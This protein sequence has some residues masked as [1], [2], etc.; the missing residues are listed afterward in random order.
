MGASIGA[1]SDLASRE[2][3]YVMAQQGANG[4]PD[5]VLVSPTDYKLDVLDLWGFK[6]VRVDFPTVMRRQF[7]IS[8]QKKLYPGN[9]PWVK[10]Q[11]CRTKTVEV[12]KALLHALLKFSDSSA[13]STFGWLKQSVSARVLDLCDTLR[14]EELPQ[15]G[16]RVMD[17]APGQFAFK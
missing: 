12:H 17:L 5:E 8:K 4:A 3:M 13:K 2:N 16:V 6:A 10:A 9:G 15:L 14:N 1:I 7:A 11:C